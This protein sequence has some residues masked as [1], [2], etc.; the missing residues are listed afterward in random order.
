MKI[1][2]GLK[3]ALSG[4]REHASFGTGNLLND[5]LL[6]RYPS[7]QKKDPPVLKNV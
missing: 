6:P 7:A 1:S 2:A 5:E 4:I 3:T